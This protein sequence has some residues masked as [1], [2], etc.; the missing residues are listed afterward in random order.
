M[1]GLF[2]CRGNF[3]GLY[4]FK[5]SV[6]VNDAFRSYH[7]LCPEQLHLSL[8]TFQEKCKIV[9]LKPIFN[10]VARTDP[11]IYLDKTFFEEGNTFL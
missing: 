8:L 6:L 7:D 5:K 1:C 11:T 2:P 3:R 10:E 9:K 4:F